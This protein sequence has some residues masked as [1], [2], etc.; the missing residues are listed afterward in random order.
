M[1]FSRVPSRF[2]MISPLARSARS[3][4]GERVRVHA[5]VRDRRDEQVDGDQV[6]APGRSSTAPVVASRSAIGGQRLAAG[7]EQFEHAVRAGP[8][9]HVAEVPADAPDRAGAREVAAGRARRSGPAS[10]RAV[11]S[12][13]A[14]T[15]AR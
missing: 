8:I 11:K 15:P 6:L 5:A 14:V 4:G 10:A 7:H 3:D 9:H 2:G 13:S 1:I 12:S